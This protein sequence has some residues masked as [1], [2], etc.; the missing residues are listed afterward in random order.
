MNAETI[1]TCSRPGC[2]KK[3][4]SNNTT[5]KCDSNC[6]SSEAP[7]THRAKARGSMSRATVA[8]LADEKVG[9][10]LV[11][12]RLVAEALGKDPDVVLEEFAQAWLEALAQKLED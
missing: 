5:G 6:R 9:A 11:R 3:L 7:P 12:F 4:R 10:T 1:K 8:K 2:D